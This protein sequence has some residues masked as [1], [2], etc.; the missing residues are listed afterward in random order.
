MSNTVRCS[1]CG[2]DSQC[3]EQKHL[4]VNGW[5]MPFDLFGYYG[6][7]TDEVEVLFG[8]RRSRNWILCHD[9]V[10]KFLALFPM[11]AE[12]LGKGTH[13][14]ESDTPCCDFA[15]RATDKFGKYERD[16]EGKLTPVEGAHYQ[17]VE[18]SQWQD[19]NDPS[20]TGE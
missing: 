9:C 8:G 19:A 11:L 1:A 12:T 15:W 18:N 7:F 2:T 16:S 4:P 6:G 3:D 14:C 20:A 5:E 10:A 13:L 17:V